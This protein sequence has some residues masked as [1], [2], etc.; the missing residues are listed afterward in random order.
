MRRARTIV[1]S[2]APLILFSCSSIAPVKVNAGDQ[3]FR[4][5]RTIVDTRLA[6]E[7]IEG[8]FVSTYRAPGCMAKYLVA[9]PDETGRTF[10]TDYAT[11]RMISPDTAVFVPVVMDRQTME[12][13]YRA[14]KLRAD[15]EAAATEIG[16]TP[17]DWPTVL[18]GAR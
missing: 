15:A 7:K 18:S 16:T 10:V 2:L 4:C 9:H 5:R 8:G 17:V 6:A 14:Y 11:G 1:L 13:D 12:S 3:C